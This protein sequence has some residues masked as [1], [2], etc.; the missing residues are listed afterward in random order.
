MDEEHYNQYTKKFEPRIGAVSTIWG[1]IVASLYTIYT[2]STIN[3]LVDI[4]LIRAPELKDAYS[5]TRAKLAELTKTLQSIS[6]NGAK[7]TMTIEQAE[8]HL[9]ELKTHQNNFNSYITNFNSI[10]REKQT[11]DSRKQY[12]EHNSQDGIFVTLKKQLDNTIRLLENEIKSMKEVKEEEEEEEEEET[13]SAQQYTVEGQLVPVPGGKK[14][15][16]HNR[17]RRV[18]R[19]KRHTPRKK[20]H[21]RSRK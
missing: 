21:T 16:R 12:S 14:N 6:T 4:Y 11:D 2:I 15:T 13:T 3:T 7:I 8:T 1:L 10:L 9:D 20:R 19:K 5:K 18:S 17:K